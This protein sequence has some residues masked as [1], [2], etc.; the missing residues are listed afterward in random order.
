MRTF[1]IS[2]IIFLG[3]I[4]TDCSKGIIQKKENCPLLTTYDYFDQLSESKFKFI[5]L[6]HRLN[7]AKGKNQSE[8]IDKYTKEFENLHQQCIQEME[9]KFPLG[10]VKIPFE[11]KR[12]TD[13]LT[14][15]NAYVSGYSFP[16]GTATSI[17]FYFTVE[18]QMHKKELW[19]IPIGIQFMDT[20]GDIIN[21]CTV[22]ANSELKTRFLVR[23]QST[24]RNLSKLIID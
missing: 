5:D 23:A 9:T 2:G 19:Y 3:F 6:E 24:F 1:I 17:C 7:K 21:Y 13:T 16:W 11:Q 15:T 20:D 4:L 14:I 8:D 10:T 22:Q 12:G 18:Y